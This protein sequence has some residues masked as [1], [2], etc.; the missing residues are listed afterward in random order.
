MHR[1]LMGLALLCLLFALALLALI[2]W[3][4][5]ME[6][7]L[8]PEGQTQAIVVLGAQV[9]PD[10]TPS[11]AL[12]RRLAVAEQAYREHP[13]LIVCCGAQGGNEPAPEGEV[14]RALL[15]AAGIP[16]ED[17][18]AET[19]S[20]NTRQNLQNAKALL[21]GRG[22]A[23]VL[24]V[25]SDYHVPRA[26]ALCEQVGLSAFGRGSPSKPQYFLRNHL[27]EGASW[28]KFLLESLWRKA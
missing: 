11:V 27:R 24:I 2:L 8:P 12:A 16:E 21:A 26:L 18:I 19:A 3:V 9:K 20:R 15:I 5:A 23:Q 28:I 4:Y 1:I 7:S 25:T 10:G 22:V 17:V 13:R 14:M 6:R